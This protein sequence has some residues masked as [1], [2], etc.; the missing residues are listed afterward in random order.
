MAKKV[1][2]IVAAAAA[3]ALVTMRVFGYPRSRTALK[4]PLALPSV[5][6]RHRSR[7]PT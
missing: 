1:L 4:P 7:V 6:R 5:I 3:V 2:W